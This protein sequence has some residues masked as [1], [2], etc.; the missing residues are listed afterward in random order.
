M[1]TRAPANWNKRGLPVKAAPLCS[2]S[3]ESIGEEIANTVTGGLGFLLAVGGLTVLIIFASLYGTAWHIVSFAI[4]GVTLVMLYGIS[5]LYHASRHPRRKRLLQMMDHAAIFLLIAGTYTPFTLV[6]LN[7]RWGWSLFGI[8]WGL[9]VA[10]I[11]LKIFFIHRFQVG[12]VLVY[13]AMSWMV[14]LALGPIRV[15][16]PEGGIALLFS[17]GL[18]YTGGLGFYAWEKL[19]F[20]HTLWHLFVLAGS[21]C[22]YCAVLF[23]VL[24][25]T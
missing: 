13:L 6:T 23:Y 17:G 24:S 20:H 21:I 2:V 10:G 9:A 15:H 25:V 4:Y 19:P 12:F 16:L 3:G 22:H 5:T 18:A 1:M 8:V 11:V 14:L 7:G